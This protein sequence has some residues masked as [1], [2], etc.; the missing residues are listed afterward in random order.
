MLCCYCLQ[1]WKCDLKYLPNISKTKL[2]CKTLCYCLLSIFLQWKFCCILQ[3]CV[4]TFP[5]S[6]HL[7]APWP[8]NQAI[9]SSHARNALQY[10]QLWWLQ[11]AE[12]C[13]NEAASSHTAASCIIFKNSTVAPGCR[14]KTLTLLTQR[15]FLG[16][17]IAQNGSGHIWQVWKAVCYTSLI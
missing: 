5:V 3:L 14:I 2:I 17:V 9:L 12:E 8:L 4:V 13:C 7:L 11:V 15:S 1:L 10:L 16:F 6:L